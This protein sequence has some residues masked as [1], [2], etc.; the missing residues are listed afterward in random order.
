MARS[1]INKALVQMA[2]ERLLAQGENPSI[3]AVRIELGNTGSKATIHRYLKELNLEA[4]IYLREQAHL[5]DP[6]TQLVGKLAAQLHQEA[7][8]VVEEAETRQQAVI[9][10]LKSQLS[11]SQQTLQDITQQNTAFSQQLTESEQRRIKAVD[12][13]QA[14][15]LTIERLTQQLADQTQLLQERDTHLKSLE[16]KHQHARDALTHYRESIKEQRDQEQRRYEQQVH[17]LQTELRQL[18]QTISVKQADITQLNIDNARFIAETSEV[19]KQLMTSDSKMQR[20]ETH[21]KACDAHATITDQ[22]LTEAREVNA[23]YLNEMTALRSQLTDHAQSHKDLE[24]RLATIQSELV[25]KNEL[26]DRMGFVNRA[27]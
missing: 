21:V 11:A 9:V 4:G 25:V 6:L 8:A 14:L 24:I 1:G 5:S 22:Q 15:A 16:E 26:F 12:D 3:D 20:L 18:T 23:D 2:Q 10:A 13:N 27:G 7:Q 17:Q 19:R